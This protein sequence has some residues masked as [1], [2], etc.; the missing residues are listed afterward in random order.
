[1]RSIGKK[2]DSSVWGICV[3]SAVTAMHV[4]EFLVCCGFISSGSYDLKHAFTIEKSYTTMI[5]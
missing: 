1:M 3:H 5:Y 2:V 4:D